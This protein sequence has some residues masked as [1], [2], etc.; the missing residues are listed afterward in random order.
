[1]LKTIT[2]TALLVLTISTPSFAH[3]PPNDETPSAQSS[4]TQSNQAAQI[5]ALLQEIA[6][7][8]ARL[9]IMQ[10]ETLRLEQQQAAL[11]QNAQQ[12]DNEIRTLNNEV[13]L[14]NLV[15]NTPHDVAN[16]L[17][18]QVIQVLEENNA[19]QMD[20]EEHNQQ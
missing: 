4:S 16:N 14:L 20:V 12:Q 6:R 2:G 17:L 3:F 8:E 11:E 15:V 7:E 10:Q 19:F 18:E 5:Q 1:M 9:A 13:Q